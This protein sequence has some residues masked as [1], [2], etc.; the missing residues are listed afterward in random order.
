M[1]KLISL[2]LSLFFKTRKKT[3]KKPLA[4][5]FNYEHILKKK[6]RAA[7]AAAM[8]RMFIGFPPIKLRRLVLDAEDKRACALLVA[9]NVLHFQNPDGGWGKTGIYDVEYTKKQ[10]KQIYETPDALGSNEKAIR[11]SSDFDNECTWGHIYY[12]VEVYIN[13]PD[14]EIKESIEKGLKFI[15]ESQHENGSWE[16][17]NHRHITYN[18]GV[19]TG[20]LGLLLDIVVNKKKITP[21]SRPLPKN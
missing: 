1:K 4:K 3:R 9:Q 5:D 19:M 16:N 6:N 2:L 15:V 7:S 13:W 18:D 8:W 17:K 10:L 14:V 11:V 21:F 12:L 20:V